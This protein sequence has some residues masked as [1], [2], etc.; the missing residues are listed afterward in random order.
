LGSFKVETFKAKTND[1]GL[2]LHLDLLQEK[3]YQTQITMVAYREKVARYFNRKVK[4]WR[5]RI[6]DLVLCKVT[7]TTKGPI[8][9]KLALNWE[10]PYKVI[11]C[12][13]P[14][15]YYLEDLE[16]KVLQRPWNAEHL[17]RYF[18]QDDVIFIFH[19]LFL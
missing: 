13:R 17:K 16:G 2:K 1:K 9:R 15:A 18:F 7:L 19:Y 6:G 12:Q 11:S 14:R 4:P 8:E 10:G 3:R 5:F